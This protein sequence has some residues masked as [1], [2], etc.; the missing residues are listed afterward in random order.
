MNNNINEQIKD[1]IIAYFGE[2]PIYSDYAVDYIDFIN[3]YANN[4]P[5]VLIS[6][7]G[8]QPFDVDE[9]GVAFIYEMQYRVIMNFNRSPENDDQIKAFFNA[10]GGFNLSGGRT[11][12][13]LSKN[14]RWITTDKLKQAYELIINYLG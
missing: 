2:I 3:E 13:L 12:S 6:K 5:A 4:A 7:D 9:N 8:E 14:G 10:V 1:L 11:I